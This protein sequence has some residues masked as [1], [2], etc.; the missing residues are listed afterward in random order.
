VDLALDGRP[1]LLEI[2]DDINRLRKLDPALAE[3]WR[4]AV[5][6]GFRAAF[7]A[8]YRAVGFLREES[9]RRG[10]YLLRQTQ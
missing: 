3:R 1:V 10:F 6:Q 2:P 8:G 7:A 5:N 9:P 4:Q